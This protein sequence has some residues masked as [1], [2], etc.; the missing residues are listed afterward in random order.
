MHGAFLDALAPAAA[1]GAGSRHP[2]TALVDESGFRA[3]WPGDEERLAGRRAAW[4]ELLSA[5]GATPVFV[6]L[7]SPD[8]SAAEGVLAAPALDADEPPRGRVP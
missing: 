3:R 7:A 5:H 8:V 4:R 6:D 2:L 1:A